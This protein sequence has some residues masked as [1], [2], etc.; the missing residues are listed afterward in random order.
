MAFSAS[1]SVFFF[2][3]RNQFLCIEIAA[4]LDL[5]FGHALSS[6]RY[7]CVKCRKLTVLHVL[8][9]GPTE[10]TGRTWNLL[11]VVPILPRKPSLTDLLDDVTLS[12]GMLL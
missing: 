3:V 5:R 7:V 1:C 9:P 11:L 2:N 10:L 6:K 8:Y 4:L 12:T